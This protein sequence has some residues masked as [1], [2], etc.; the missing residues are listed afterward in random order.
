LQVARAQ[1][2]AIKMVGVG[3]SDP[4]LLAAPNT[5]GVPGV[6][7]AQSTELLQF[8][9]EGFPN[10]SPISVVREAN[11]PSKL[12]QV[13]AI[14]NAAAAGVVVN[15]RPIAVPGDIGGALAGASGA[16]VLSSPLTIRSANQIV[17]A[18]AS[19][20]AIY[21]GQEFVQAGGLMGW[22]T[23]RHAT[24]RE[25]GRMACDLCNDKAMPAQSPPFVMGEILVN[26]GT[27]KD[28]AAGFPGGAIPHFHRPV[29]VI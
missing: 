23:D 6:S 22:G 28:A 24:Y 10:I 3:V 16:I 25:A 1:N 21:E 7:P 17:T 29:R 27:A 26:S 12:N 2:A 5:T 18:V 20:K 14:Q 13:T 9:Q 4:A 11:N 8:L 15:D 19:I